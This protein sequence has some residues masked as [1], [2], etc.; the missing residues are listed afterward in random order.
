MTAAAEDQVARWRGAGS[1][2]VAAI[3]RDMSETTFH[4]ISATMFAGSADTEAAAIMHASE[5]ALATVSW[6][7][8]AA[9]LR[10]PHWMWYPGKFSRR[11]AGRDLRAAVAADPGAPARDGPR[12]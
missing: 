3:D 1:G 2:A 4:V 9:M 7:I 6:D 10:L 11:R 5:R 12:R 8:A